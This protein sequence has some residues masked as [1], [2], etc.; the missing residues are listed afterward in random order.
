MKTS[1]FNYHLPAEN[2]AQTPRL[3]RESCRLAIVDRTAGTLEH[4]KFDDLLSY[5][6]KGDCLVL[7][8]SAVAACRIPCVKEGTRAN[9]EVFLTDPADLQKKT[10]DVLFRP[11]R[12]VAVGTQLRPARHAAAGV[13]IVTAKGPGSHG[14]V[15]WQGTEPL[16]DDFLW[17]QIGVAP[18]PPY[19]KRERLPKEK[20]AALDREYY[21]TTYA[22]I[23]GSAAAPTAGLHFSTELLAKINNSGIEIARITLHVGMGTFLPVKTETIEEHKIHRENFIITKENALKICNCRKN[24]GRVIAVGTTALRALESAWTEAAGLKTGEQTTEIYIIPG[25]RFKIVDALITN[26]H[27]PGSTLLMLVSAFYTTGKMLDVYKMCI[28]KKYL[29]LSYG[30]AMLIF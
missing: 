25:Y 14:S 23:S 1:N 2:I 28:N 16:S 6:Q 21:Q 11:A 8:D 22:K 15:A 17:Q 9:V 30:D 13:F 19:I 29:F 24:G 26:F 5:L 18:L 20:I 4:K 3:K 7:N 27:Q 10:L 12:K